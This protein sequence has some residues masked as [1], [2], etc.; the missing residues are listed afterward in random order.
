MSLVK[1]I[2]FQHGTGIVPEDVLERF[3]VSECGNFILFLGELAYMNVVSS[4]NN[5]T[6]IKGGMSLIGG[7]RSSLWVGG[8][9]C[10][11]KMSE[12]HSGGEAAYVDNI[13][14]ERQD[15]DTVKVIC[16]YGV[17][18]YS[19]PVFKIPGMVKYVDGKA[20]PTCNNIGVSMVDTDNIIQRIKDEVQSR[21]NPF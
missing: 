1:D 5:G 18:N 15:G 12:Y 11:I 17:S 14:G 21:L 20:A 2:Y 10:V 16:R 8:L 6:N 9:F 19:T 7:A 3:F 13:F 4:I